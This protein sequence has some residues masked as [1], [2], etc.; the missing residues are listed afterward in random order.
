MAAFTEASLLDVWEAAAGLSA[1]R[2]ALAL[3]VAGGAEPA[4]VGD[5]AVGRRD[6][7]LLALRERCFGTAFPCL[8]N[9]PSCGEELELELSSRELRPSRVDAPTVVA[10]CEFRAVTSRD[11]LEVHSR[12]E[13]LERCVAG[14]LSEAALAALPDALAAAD[15]QADVRIELDCAVCGHRWA[16][17]FDIAAYLWT[18]LEACARRLLY[19][20]HALAL[21]YG[22]SEAEVLAVSPGRRRRYLELAGTVA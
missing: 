4:E 13:L 22:W 11:L 10:G 6:E 7:F 17:P 15:P 1:V 14:E 20:V 12:Q 3:A 18:E 5:L 19:D 21:A 8:V 2:R 9:C 16:S